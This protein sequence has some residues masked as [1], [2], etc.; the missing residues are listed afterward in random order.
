MARICPNVRPAWMVTSAQNLYEYVATGTFP[1]ANAT[2]SS[3]STISTRVEDPRETE[4]CLFLDVI[5]PESIFRRADQGYRAPV[6]VWIH[7]M[8]CRS[9]YGIA[10]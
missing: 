8:E 9:F 4:D 5:V 7:G 2:N 10:S 6:L 3:S 1:A